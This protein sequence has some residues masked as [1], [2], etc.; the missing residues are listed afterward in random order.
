M[1]IA[2]EWCSGHHGSM[3][4]EAPLRDLQNLVERAHTIIATDPIPAGG[5]ERAADLLDAARSLIDIMLDYASNRAEVK[6]PY[7]RIKQWRDKRTSTHS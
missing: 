6:P 1:R 5:R 2:F 3:V 7:W 4:F